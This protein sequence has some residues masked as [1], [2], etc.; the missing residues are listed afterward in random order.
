MNIQNNL[1]EV[2]SFIMTNYKENECTKVL[3]LIDELQNEI[4]SLNN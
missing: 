4:D 2:Y 1:D 3:E